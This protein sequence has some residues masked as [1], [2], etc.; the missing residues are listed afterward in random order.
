MQNR[1]NHKWIL[2]LIFVLGNI[3]FAKAQSDEEQLKRLE[4]YIENTDQT[5]DYNDL[6]DQVNFGINNKL[7]LN[8]A[9]SFELLSLDILTPLQV[10]AIIKHR[11]EFGNFASPLELQT[12]DEIPLEILKLLIPLLTVVEANLD[13]KNLGQHIIK[14]QKNITG[15]FSTSRPISKGFKTLTNDSTLYY[16]GSPYRYQIRFSANYKNAVQYGFN[17]EKDE[18]EDFFIN[19]NRQG[20][21]YYSA[22]FFINKKGFIRK[23]ALGDFQVAFGQGLTMASGLGFGKSAL[24]LNVKR[25]NT[26]LRPYR[27]FNENEFLRGGGITL[28]YKNFEST[29]FISRNKIDGNLDTINMEAGLETIT[30]SF[31]TDGYHR[32]D[33]EISKEKNVTKTLIGQNFNYRAKNLMLGFTNVFNSFDKSLTLDDKIY[34]R[35]YFQ[36]KQFFKTGL[37]FDYYFK[38]INLFGEATTGTNTANGYIAG[39]YI[40]LG[41]TIDLVIVN[42]YYFKQFIWYNTNAFSENSNPNNERGTYVGFNIKP[43][44]KL[45]FSGFV[46]SYKMPWYSY[47]V[48]GRGNGIDYLTELNFKPTKTSVMYVRLRTKQELKN[49]DLGNFNG[50]NWTEKSNVRFHAEFK[51]L[52]NVTLKSRLEFSKYMTPENKIQTGNLMYLDFVYRQLNSPI[53]ISTRVTFFNIKDFNARIYAAEND[54]LYSWSVPGFSGSGTKFYAL[55]KYK[56]KNMFLQCRY[57]FTTYYDRQTIGSGYTTVNS[58]KL[59][60]INLLISYGFM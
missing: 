51:I 5:G 34:N 1:R 25:F 58:N 4:K 13:F 48:D 46:D 59:H 38:N 28:G 7:N 21:D 52:P 24:V 8:K 55:T 37:H 57:A 10:R 40:S 26:G 43:S 42:R 44:K 32:T 20:F 31:V 50:L 39:A 11:I 17:A 35:Y 36:G 16:P 14:A 29:T 19:S 56:Y 22:H 3:I 18:G 23:I 9:T 6:A 27:S 15:L 47:Y 54:V 60:E 12:I 53:S 33:L 45:T 49:T 30:K 41:S 2:F